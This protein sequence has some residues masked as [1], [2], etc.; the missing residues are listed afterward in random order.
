MTTCEKETRAIKF[1][2]HKIRKVRNVHRKDEISKVG[3]KK[4]REP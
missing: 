1:P 2:R 3:E 4:G